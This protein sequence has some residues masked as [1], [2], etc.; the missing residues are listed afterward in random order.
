MRRTTH[1]LLAAVSLAA[2][3][4]TAVFAQA[5]AK[6]G[7]PHAVAVDPALPAYSA[8]QGVSGAIKSVGSDTLNNVMAHWSELFKKNYP[9]VQVES[10]GKGS[11]TAPPA[12]TNGQ[13]Q[14]APM[15]REMSKKELD[16]FQASHGYE[17]TK[18]RVAIDCLAVFVNKD[19]PLEQISVEQ[20]KKIF[21][22][23]GPDMTW[24]DLGVTAP[25]W[26]SKP[27]SLYGRLSNSGTYA[28]FKDHALGGKDYKKTVKEQ[29]GSSA[30]VQG[31]AADTYAMGYSGIGYR[32]SG[33]KALRLSRDG[34]TGTEPTLE[35]ALSGEYALAR[36]LYVYVNRDPRAGLDPLRAE[37]VKMIYTKEGQESVI[38]DGYFPVP[39]D[40]ARE[41][42]KA[43]GLTPGF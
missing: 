4:S 12:L 3:L 5:T 11:G 10:E 18:L 42:L 1:V 26:K 6:P 32:T 37:F 29:P 34:A 23:D 21:S 9:A 14:L 30:V 2:S 35:N 27:I 31:V 39:A 36:F 13:S 25:A 24:G 28:Y 43:A 33:V 15:S 41:D 16:A 8:A 17:P 19:C 38:K 20:A 40:V 22:V 7:E